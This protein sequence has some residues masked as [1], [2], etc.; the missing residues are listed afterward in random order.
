[1][2]I[3]LLVAFYGDFKKESNAIEDHSF[4]LFT[5]NNYI[6]TLDDSEEN[7]EIKYGFQLF[8]STPDFVGPNNGDEEIAYAGNNLSC[9][10]CHLYAGTKPYSGA[11]I[12]VVKRFPQFRGRENKMGTIEERINGCFE[13]SMNGRALPSDGKEMKAFVSYLKWLDRFAEPDGSFDGQGFVS[14][15]IPERPVDLEKGKLIFDNLCFACHGTDGKGV[16]LESSN[17]YQYPPLWGDDS[18]NNGAGMNRVITAAEFIKG[19]MPY[20]AT[21]KNP[22][23]TDEQAYD[24]SGY[25]NQQQRPLKSNPEK[26]FP[27]LTKKP[28]STPY[29]PYSDNFSIEQHQLGPFQPI[30]EYY[31]V[32]Y[33]IKKKN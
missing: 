4:E 28:V 31:W 11:L 17:V 9:N 33:G 6:N 19:N 3:F 14:I 13:R 10:N 23:L 1:M 7:L 27:D 22:I 5:I 15:E 8:K 26:D 29:P 21:H 2:V 32:T 25:I 12:G 18:F 30:M 16:K 20:G 24:V